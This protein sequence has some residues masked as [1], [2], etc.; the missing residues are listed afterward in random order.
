[1]SRPESL[2]YAESARGPVLLGAMYEMPSLGDPGP[3]IGGPLTMWHAHEN[4]CFGLAPPA[5]VG[6]MSPFGGCPVTSLTIPITPEM[7][8]LWLIP[9]APVFGEVEDEVR[10][11]YLASRIAP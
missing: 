11:A 8:H 7:I 3:A 2:I 1:L 6:L 9:G 10:R 4:V 5:F